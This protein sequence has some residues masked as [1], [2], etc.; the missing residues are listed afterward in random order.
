[1]LWSSGILSQASAG[2]ELVELPI[3]NRDSLRLSCFDSD[4]ATGV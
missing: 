2:A 1:M 4:S 3:M